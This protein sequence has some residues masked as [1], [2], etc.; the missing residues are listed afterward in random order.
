MPPNGVTD[1]AKA[2]E[3]V[4]HKPN[5]SDVYE[6]VPKKQLVLF[7]QFLSEVLTYQSIVQIL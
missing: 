4:L 5:H 3:E 7:V 6:V 1:D 2:I